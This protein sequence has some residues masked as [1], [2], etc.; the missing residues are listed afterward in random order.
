MKIL[1]KKE[2]DW[3]FNAWVEIETVTDVLNLVKEYGPIT[4]KRF[5]NYTDAVEF[6]NDYVENFPDSRKSAVME[7]VEVSKRFL[8]TQYKTTTI[9]TWDE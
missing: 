5:D 8:R 9:T 6:F 3:N 4:E 7:K 1:V 2:S